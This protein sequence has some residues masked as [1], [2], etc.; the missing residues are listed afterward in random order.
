MEIFSSVKYFAGTVAIPNAFP[1]LATIQVHKRLGLA[2][3]G[4][5]DDV[6][7]ITQRKPQWTI[8]RTVSVRDVA[9]VFATTE[10]D[11][12]EIRRK[13]LDSRNWV[14]SQQAI[15]KIAGPKTGIAYVSEHASVIIT[16][17]FGMSAAEGADYCP[18]VHYSFS[19]CCIPSCSK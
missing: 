5:L 18:A 3:G 7:Q 2:G 14:T 4:K 1:E 19:N 11:P 15:L 16:V 9:G 17:E 13:W 8:I 10:T 6:L 12:D